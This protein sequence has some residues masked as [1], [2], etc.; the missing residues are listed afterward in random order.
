MFFVMECWHGLKCGLNVKGLWAK[1]YMIPGDIK[2]RTAVLLAVVDFVFNY[3]NIRLHSA[4][5]YVAPANKLLGR[6]KQTF[7]ES[8]DTVKSCGRKRARPLDF[9]ML[10]VSTPR[11]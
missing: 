6:D 3:N 4:L 7:A 10:P 5:G 1:V 11:L 9:L 8:G 2:Y